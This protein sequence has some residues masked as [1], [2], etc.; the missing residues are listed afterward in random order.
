MST[1]GSLYRSWTIRREPDASGV[2]RQ[3]IS[4]ALE[5]LAAPATVADV[6]L[7]TSELVTNV[8]MHTTD[9]CVVSLTFDP[10]ERSVLVG[11]TDA[12]PARGA[13]IE[14][15][16]VAGDVGGFGLR[17]V[18]SIAVRWGCEV[19]VDSKT[20]WFELDTHEP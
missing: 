8:M 14:P 19:G 13:A 17:L 18:D 12:S 5:P 7:L 10:A 9:I 15:E 1:N 3:L 20:V 4:E 2:S 11:V 6:A 16:R